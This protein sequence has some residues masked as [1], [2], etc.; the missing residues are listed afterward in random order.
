MEGAMEGIK[1]A[2][3]Q[4]FGRRALNANAGPTQRGRA[5]RGA[6]PGPSVRHRRQPRRT[7]EYFGPR[8]HCAG[9]GGYGPT[10]ARVLPTRGR[11]TR[12][13]RHW[14]CGPGTWSRWIP[15][16]PDVEPQG[17]HTGC[18]WYYSRRHEYGHCTI[19][20]CRVRLSGHALVNWSHVV[21]DKDSTTTTQLGILVHLELSMLPNLTELS[22]VYA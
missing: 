16:V 20:V 9:H 15:T 13:L 19:L 6:L 5:R 22:G 8:F 7:Q 11:S 14:L 4:G 17:I 1:Q 2:S 12:G 18:R 10:T 21:T 3:T